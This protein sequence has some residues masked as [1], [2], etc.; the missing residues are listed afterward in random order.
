MTWH[1]Q[2]RLLL[3]SIAEFFAM[4]QIDKNLWLSSYLSTY[5]ERDLRSMKAITDL[6]RFQTFIGLLAGR[7]GQLLNMTN[8][9]KR[10]AL[11]N[12]LSKIG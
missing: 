7:A 5:I 4:P 12:Q 8:W 3:V 1:V 2:I 11:V 9:P 10:W 6:T